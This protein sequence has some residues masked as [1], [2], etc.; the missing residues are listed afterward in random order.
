MSNYKPYFTSDKLV[1]SVQRTIMAPLS[2]STFRYD[3]ILAF[4]NEE[5]QLSAV[6]QVLQANQEYFVYKKMVEVIDNINRYTI[7]DR[8]IGTA[9]RDLFWSDQ[10][11][12]YYEM[13][14]IAPDDKA[15]FQQN[16]AANN[17]LNK[18]YL[19]GND[20]VLAPQQA[21]GSNGSYLNFFINLR[22]NFLVRDDR[23]AKIVE[24]RAPIVIAD[25]SL[26][27]AGD[28][29]QFNTGVTSGSPETFTFFAKSSGSPLPFEFLIGATAN[30]TAANLATA[31]TNAN[32]GISATI[33]STLLSRLWLGYEDVT[34]AYSSNRPL[35][36][37]ITPEFLYIKFDNA[38]RPTYT[39][40]DTGV[41]TDLYVQNCLVDF[42]QTLPGHKTYAYDVK[43]L[44]VLSDNVGKFLSKE[45]KTY[46]SN[47]S[48]GYF[49]YQNMK[50]GDYI[51]LQNEC[52]IPQIPPELHPALAQRTATRVLAAMGDREGMAVTMAKVQEMN[53]AQATMIT[54]RV[55][56]SPMKVFNRFGILRLQK[57]GARRRI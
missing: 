39:N 14:R 35:A 13:S 6:P 56:G 9:L 7:P 50:V 41:T 15:F 30:D 49:Q 4:A 46:L 12:N 24:F 5:L 36:I 23:A 43:L 34:N 42:L 19:E 21:L 29:V 44:E 51:G 27:Q 20:I 18:F 40:I 48:S 26:L 37:V 31:I 1:E 52:I 11:G 16:I 32:I 25:N 45:L 55:E 47:S 3:D 8:A 57:R 54:D 38:F 53:Q 10:N 22:P 2:Q 33:D 28:F 17:W